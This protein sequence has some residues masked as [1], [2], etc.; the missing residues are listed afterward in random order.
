[1]KSTFFTLAALAALCM[2]LPAQGEKPI[3]K[4]KSAKPS[5]EVGVSG[6]R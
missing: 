5:F 3:E 6:M 1:M 2:S 4:K